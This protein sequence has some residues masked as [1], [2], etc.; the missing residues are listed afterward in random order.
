ML[1]ESARCIDLRTLTGSFSRV[2]R[3]R[4]LFTAQASVDPAGEIGQ[5]AAAD[6]IVL[7][8]RRQV[9]LRNAR[10]RHFCPLVLGRRT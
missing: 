8:A 6:R 1:S 10:L 3:F 7:G 4:M 2:A 9:I 5:S